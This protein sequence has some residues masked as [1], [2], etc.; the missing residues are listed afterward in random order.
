MLWIVGATHGFL[1][2]FERA[3]HSVYQIAFVMHMV[4]F[5]CLARLRKISTFAS[6]A[7]GNREQGHH[8]FYASHVIEG[9]LVG[10]PG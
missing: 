9:H 2:A 10:V 8:V 6:L 5:M 4:I 3:N 7:S 1:H